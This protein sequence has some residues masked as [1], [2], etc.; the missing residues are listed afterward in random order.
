MD[1]NDYFDNLS[2]IQRFMSQNEIINI[3]LR[4]KI[5][6]NCKY[7]DNINKEIRRISNEGIIIGTGKIFK[8]VPTIKWIYYKWR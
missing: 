6:N 3:I 7:V 8:S 1:L 2:D 5:L 4:K